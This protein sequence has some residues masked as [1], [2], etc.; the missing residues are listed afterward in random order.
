MTGVR[1]GGPSVADNMASHGSDTDRC[2]GLPTS[3]VCVATRG[4]EEHVRDGTRA[5]QQTC[6]H[7]THRPR[8]SSTTAQRRVWDVVAA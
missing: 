2:N 6:C 3:S 4:A 5:P 7:I 1:D 8:I